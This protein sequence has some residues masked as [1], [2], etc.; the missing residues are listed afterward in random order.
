LRT[1]EEELS[2]SFDH[3]LA[4]ADQ[5]FLETGKLRSTLA[6]LARRLDEAGISY[7][8]LG[9]IALARYGYQRMTVDI[10]LLLSPEGLSRFQEQ[11]V[12]RGYVA[13][14]NGATKSFR[15]TDTGV[16]IDVI[17]SGEYPGDGRP[18]PV[19]FPEPAEVAI[20]VDGVRVVRLPK[21]IEFKLASGISAPHRL[22]DLADVQDAIRILRLPEDLADRLDTSVRSA[23]LDLWRRAQV[24]DPRA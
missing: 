19:V 8:I 13:A 12:G 11:Y 3:L 16:R 15:A 22:R 14:F 9:A 24:P 20:E 17:T 21:L 10:D 6:D 23:Y 5:Y 1:Y 7:A 2:E 18:K 4:E